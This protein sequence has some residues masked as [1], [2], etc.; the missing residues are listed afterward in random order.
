M[1]RR[2]ESN[3]VHEQRQQQRQPMTTTTTKSLSLSFSL[4]WAIALE[5]WAFNVTTEEI[6][7]YILFWFYLLHF[8]LHCHRLVFCTIFLF[9]FFAFLSFFIT[10][11][12]IFTSNS[13]RMWASEKLFFIRFNYLKRRFLLPSIAASFS[14]ASFFT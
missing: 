5:N 9:F 10:C 8:A 6:W 14:K 11:F 3:I 1:E 12:F 7:R 4:S 2:K 13:N